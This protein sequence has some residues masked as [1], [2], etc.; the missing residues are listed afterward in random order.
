MEKVITLPSGKS[1]TIK[2]FKG[3][4]IL[5]AQKK[6]GESTERML[7]AL[8]SQCVLIDN[9]FVLMEDLEEMDGM[10]CLA[11]MGEFGTNFTSAPSN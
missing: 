3:R 8:M 5:E 4:D 9:Q 11:L 2:K 1:A 7:F 10:D 6:A